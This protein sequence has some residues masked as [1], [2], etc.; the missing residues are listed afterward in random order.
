MVGPEMVA[1]ALTILFVLAVLLAVRFGS[2][3][4][5]AENRS[6]DPSSEPRSSGSTSVTA[7]YEVGAS[8]GWSWVAEIDPT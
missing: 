4:G 1:L 5:N 2:P 7:M 6:A 3:S 8:I